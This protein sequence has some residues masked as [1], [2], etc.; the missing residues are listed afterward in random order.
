MDLIGDQGIYHGGVVPQTNQDN[1][2]SR[3]TNIYD[4][5][6]TREYGAVDVTANSDTS[7]TGISPGKGNHFKKQK[8]Q[9]LDALVA[10]DGEILLQHPTI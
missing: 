9:K 8:N 1:S 10:P 7:K 4:F 3:R 5:H 6:L 2:P